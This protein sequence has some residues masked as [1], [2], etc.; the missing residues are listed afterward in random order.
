MVNVL[1]SLFSA[2]PEVN[3]DLLLCNM[4]Q[5]IYVF[6]YFFILYICF[7]IDDLH[8][9]YNMTWVRTWHVRCWKDPEI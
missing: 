2:K 7:V 3:V 4:I 5:Y 8:I 9:F 1:H 6:S